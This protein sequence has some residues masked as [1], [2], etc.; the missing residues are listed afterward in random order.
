M[1]SRR[2]PINRPND[3]GACVEPEVR[4][5]AAGHAEAVLR[6]REAI[7]AGDVYQ[8]CLTARAWVRG[9][10]GAALLARMVARGAPRVR[11]PLSRPRGGPHP[12]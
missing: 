11:Q 10:D 9:V 7:A 4:L 12:A 1:A 5:E 2:D 6:I 8:V 3:E